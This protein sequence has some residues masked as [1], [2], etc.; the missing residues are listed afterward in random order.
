MNREEKKNAVQ[1][2]KERFQKASIT[3]LADYKGLK[4]NEMNELRQ[5]L[6]KTSAKLQVVKNT[7]ARLAIEGT[8]MKPL[9]EHFKGTI[10]VVTSEG[11]PVSPT[12]ALIDFGKDREVPA[13]KAGFMSGEIMDHAKVEAL[14]KL[15]SREEMLAKLLGSMQAPAQ[16]MVNVFAAIPRQLVTVLAAIRDQKQA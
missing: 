5:K 12:K 16:N 1:D 4:V 2:L 6:L 3:I 14:S 8:E 15:P 13:V 11:D 10:A 7:L 9:Q